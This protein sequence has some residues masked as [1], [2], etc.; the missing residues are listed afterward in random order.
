MSIIVR[1]ASL[2][3]IPA[4]FTMGHSDVA[5]TVSDRIRFY[6]K[7]ELQEWIAS[8]KDNILLVLVAD[9]S[10]DLAG[11]L[12][13]KIMSYHWAMLDNFYI[14]PSFRGQ[15]CD[16]LLMEELAKRLRQR[17]IA[18]LTALTANDQPALA[19]YLKRHGFRTASLYQWNELFLDQ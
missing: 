13:C 8:P 18:Y 16:G 15:H 3:D 2:A 17:R 4:I 10:S 1:D 6:E 14:Q 11:F 5:F 19:R 7:A 9:S 12:F